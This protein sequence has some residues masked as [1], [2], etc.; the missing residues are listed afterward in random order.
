MKVTVRVDGVDYVS[1][2][3]DGDVRDRAEK[4][5]NDIERME[6]LGL[7]I[8]NGRH[9]IFPKDVLRRAVIIVED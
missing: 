7:M 3:E 6:A 5:G 1:V 8:G 2:D 9:V 4:I